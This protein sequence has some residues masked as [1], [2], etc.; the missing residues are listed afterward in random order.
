M[1]NV[2]GI[3]IEIDGFK[4]GKDIGVLLDCG[5]GTYEQIRDHY[6]P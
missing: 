6:Q 5:A 3:I 2:S 4:G 1:R